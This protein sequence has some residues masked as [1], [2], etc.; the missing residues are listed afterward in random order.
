MLYLYLYFF[1]LYLLIIYTIISAYHQGGNWG[2]ERLNYVPKV[3]YL[4]TDGV[5]SGAQAI[6][7]SG[8]KVLAILWEMRLMRQGIQGRKIVVEAMEIVSKE[9]M[10][11]K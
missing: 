2:L 7:S 1:L 9:K 8:K 5:M 6:L 11:E 10:T 3:P 4:E